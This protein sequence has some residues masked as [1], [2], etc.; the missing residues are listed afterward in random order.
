VFGDGATSTPLLVL[1]RAIKDSDLRE[2]LVTIFNDKDG[3]TA[4]ALERAIDELPGINQLKYAPRVYNADVGEELVSA[5]ERTRSIPSLFFLDPCGYKGLTLR[6]I[7]RAVNGWGCDCIVFFNYRRINMGLNND[8]FK[9]HMDGLFGEKRASD[10]RGRLACLDPGRRESVIVEEFVK[11]INEIGGRYVLPFRFV[12]EH[13]TRTSHH[14]VFISKNVLG[15]SIMKDIMAKESTLANQGVPSFEY[16]PA[17][18]SQP[19]LFELTR[20]L[21]DLEFLLLEEFAGRTLTMK[22]VF[23]A[24]HVGRPFIKRNYKKSLLHLEQ[25]GRITA[26]PPATNRCKRNGQPTFADAVKVT[27]PAR[28]G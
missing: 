25:Q 21:S 16:S 13:Q 27:F 23:E 18:Q 4:M 11:S 14:L 15:Y 7:R 28:G 17:D 12:D 10:L 20:P 22:E 1:K 3:E 19:N 24:H 2:F 26:E 8:L 6:L 9:E 5:L